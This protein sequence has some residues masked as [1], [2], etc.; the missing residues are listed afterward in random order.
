MRPIV[1]L[2]TMIYPGGLLK[3]TI[4]P[5][6]LRRLDHIGFAVSQAAYDYPGLDSFDGSY[7]IL[8]LKPNRR[9]N[10]KSL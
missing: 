2:V 10:D 8:P 9:S 6:Y 5:S 4:Y 3:R 7:T 1:S